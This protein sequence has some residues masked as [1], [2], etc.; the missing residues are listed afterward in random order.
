MPHAFHDFEF[1][2]DAGVLRRAGVVV[3]LQRQPCRVLAYLLAHP[4][5]AISR[6]ELVQHLWPSD[7]HVNFDQGLNYCV[8]Q[9]RRALGDDAAAPRFVETVPQCGYRWMITAQPAAGSPAPAPSW[10]TWRVPLGA[11]L[12]GSLICSVLTAFVLTRVWVGG[13]NAASMSHHTPSPHLREAVGAL[14]VLSHALVEPHRR[15]DARPAV[16]RLWRV[17]ADHDTDFGVRPR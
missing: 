10:W 1:D 9:V 17:V 16:A 6:A 7:H 2:E 13:D 5:R 14:H 3:R 11:A 12:A 8:R 15:A 4:G